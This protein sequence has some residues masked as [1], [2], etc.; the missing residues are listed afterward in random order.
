MKTSIFAAT[1]VRIETKSEI[2]AYPKGALIQVEADTGG[3]VYVVHHRLIEDGDEKKD[4]DSCSLFGKDGKI[5]DGKCVV[6]GKSYDYPKKR[7]ESSH[8]KFLRMEDLRFFASSVVFEDQMSKTIDFRDI[9]LSEALLVERL[10]PAHISKYANGTSSLEKRFIKEGIEFYR[11][12]VMTRDKVLQ[13]HEKTSKIDKFDRI[14]TPQKS[15]DI[16]V[17]SAREKNNANQ[18]GYL[19]ALERIL[20]NDVERHLIGYIEKKITEAAESN[21]KVRKTENSVNVNLNGQRP[22]GLYNVISSLPVKV[23]V[24][25]KKDKD[26]S[27]MELSLVSPEL[28][29]VVESYY[30]KET[31][32][33][34][35][36]LIEAEGDKQPEEGDACESGG[37][38]GSLQKQGDSMVCMVKES[39][40]LNFIEEAAEGDA[41]E[42]EGGKKG[43]MKMVNGTL[44]CVIMEDEKESV[45]FTVPVREEKFKKGQRVS[46]PQ[47]PG[48]VTSGEDSTT[49]GD[50]GGGYTLIKV[51]L[52]SGKEVNVSKTALSKESYGEAEMQ[53]GSR[54]SA[55]PA[56]G[57]P[58][59]Y[60]GQQGY[61]ALVNGALI[62]GLGGQKPPGADGAN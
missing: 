5:K 58:C 39:L 16:V 20:N 11:L 55:S 4:G 18:T 8:L 51:Q 30:T 41:C 31:A 33:S 52:D 22:A 24:K 40:N 42:S 9:S 26:D 34:K 44:A 47:G 50:V 2:F 61:L 59:D 32:Y 13:D 37:K 53:P 27:F 6:E 19:V 56:V 12:P 15:D 45:V 36:T 25:S 3:D 28:E 35:Y 29:N 23:E 1:D 21:W 46:T 7:V 57:D 14:E 10:T 60:Q 48:V 17:I 54:D 43:T 62:C 38:K 49:I